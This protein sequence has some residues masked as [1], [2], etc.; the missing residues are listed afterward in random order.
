MNDFDLSDAMLSALTADSQSQPQPQLSID[1]MINY[2]MRNIN[3]VPLDDKISL[4]KVLDMNGHR[5]KM[6]ESTSGLMINLNA[7]DEET[8][9]KMYE[10][11][12]YKISKRNK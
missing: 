6:K 1:S 4:G 8:I 7:L 9:R 12:D 10:L 2:L 3:S 11:L 5:D